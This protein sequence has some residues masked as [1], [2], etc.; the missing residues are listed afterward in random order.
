MARRGREAAW[1]GWGA[2][3]DR[4]ILGKE[5]ARYQEAASFPYVGPGFKLIER[6]PRAD[7]ANRLSR[8][9]VAALFTAHVAKLFETFRAHDDRELEP[10]RYFL[11]R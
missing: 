8:A 2:V 7:G 5:A 6:L 9:I 10:T 4:C 1:A 3:T 11:P